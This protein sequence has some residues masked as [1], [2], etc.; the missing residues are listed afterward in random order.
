MKLFAKT[1]D[2]LPYLIRIG[3]KRRGIFREIEGRIIKIHVIR[4]TDALQFQI[5][6]P[7]DHGPGRC[8]RIR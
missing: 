4:K 7:P 8:F 5:H 1:L 2:L 3:S 6:S